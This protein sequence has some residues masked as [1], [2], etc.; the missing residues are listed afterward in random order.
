[1]DRK[2]CYESSMSF[3]GKGI[4]MRRMFELFLWLAVVAGVP[5]L[6]GMAY[7]GEVAAPGALMA[8]E[9]A[10]DMIHGDVLKVDRDLA[11][12]IIKHR[13]MV[14]LGMPAMT[15]LFSVPDAAVLDSLKVGACIKFLAQIAPHGLAVT[16]IESVRN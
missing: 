10:G 7:A 3:I 16:K 15:M 4:Y 2:D 5:S 12:V 14:A 6:N 13:E 11:K 1:M 9:H 8:N